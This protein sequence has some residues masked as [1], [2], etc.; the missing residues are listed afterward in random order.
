LQISTC[1][2]TSRYGGS[3]VLREHLL[4]KQGGGSVDPAASNQRS[5][6][7]APTNQRS[8]PPRAC[9]RVGANSQRLSHTCS[10]GN[11]KSGASTPPRRLHRSTMGTFTTTAAASPLLPCTMCTAAPAPTP[12]PQTVCPY[13]NYTATVAPWASAIGGLPS[14]TGRRL[15]GWGCTS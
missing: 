5:A 12:A 3:L 10:Y 8:T 4:R 14:C 6:V 15:P 1:S 7:D 2:A 13:R 9:S 11:N